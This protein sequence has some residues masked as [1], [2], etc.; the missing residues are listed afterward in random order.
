MVCT[1]HLENAIGTYLLCTEISLYGLEKVPVFLLWLAKHRYFPEAKDR[2]STNPPCTLRF[3][4]KD[5][6]VGI[7]RLCGLTF[8]VHIQQVI[9]KYAKQSEKQVGINGLSNQS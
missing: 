3:S 2:W 1:V 7:T 8:T 4:V 5:S 9:Y 6:V